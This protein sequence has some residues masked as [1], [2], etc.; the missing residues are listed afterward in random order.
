MSKKHS[1]SS[2]TS[3]WIIAADG[4]PKNER[5]C[6]SNDRTTFASIID[7]TTG[8]CT[9]EPLHIIGTTLPSFKEWNHWHSICLGVLPMKLWIP[10]KFSHSQE[11]NPLDSV[12]ALQLI[13]RQLETL[14]NM[15]CYPFAKKTKIIDYKL[16]KEDASNPLY[17]NSSVNTLLRSR[18]LFH[19]K[20]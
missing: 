9:K 14:S 2:Q 15:F 1:A 5:Q 11:K 18:V 13:W 7:G 19:M 4:T 8:F 3:K 10:M 6:K 16:G 12:R 17:Y 20:L